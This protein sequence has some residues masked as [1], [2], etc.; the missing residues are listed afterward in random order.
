VFSACDRQMHLVEGC[1]QVVDAHE[2]AGAWCEGG[3]KGVA[4]GRQ[5]G[6][7]CVRA[8]DGCEAPEIFGPLAQRCALVGE[9]W[10]PG[11]CEL[12]AFKR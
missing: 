10:D 9:R 3:G 1:A 12:L 4:E 8:G 7:L 2:G 11:K 5:G 6:I